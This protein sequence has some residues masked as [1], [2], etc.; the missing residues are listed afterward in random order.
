M[1]F[2][3]S[4]SDKVIEKYELG[5]SIIKIAKET[6]ASEQISINVKRSFVKRILKKNNTKI[7]TMSEQYI[8]DYKTGNRDRFKQ[9]KK[10]NIALRGSHPSYKTKLKH[11]SFIE[12]NHSISLEQSK[13]E[14]QFYDY[15]TRNSII[16]TYQKQFKQYNVDFYFLS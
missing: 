6:F 10:A 15:L 16:F 5:N 1:V 8:E 4:Y 7:R 11:A 13:Y 3:D 14:K 12:N 2:L 9:T